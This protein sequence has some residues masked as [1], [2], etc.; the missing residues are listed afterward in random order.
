M[1][2]WNRFDIC[3]AWFLYASHFHSGQWSALYKVLGRLERMQFKPA[4]TLAL[5]SLTDNGRA[6]YVALVKRAEWRIPT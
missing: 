3:E 6:I 5:E 2:T 1:A 4:P